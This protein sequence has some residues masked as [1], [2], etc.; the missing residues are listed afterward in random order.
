M[1]IAIKFRGI[2][3]ILLD[4][5]NKDDLLEK[6]KNALRLDD[7][8]L[9]DLE[10]PKNMDFS[11]EDEL[12][13]IN[14][15][16]TLQFIPDL[17]KNVILR[18]I[19]LDD[20]EP[21]I[22]LPTAADQ[23]PDEKNSAALPEKVVELADLLKD[24][25]TKAILAKEPG[26]WVNSD[27][28]TLRQYLRNT[29]TLILSG[30]DDGENLYPELL[31]LCSPT[32][33]RLHL[34]N[35][36]IGEPSE[37]PAGS[38]ANSLQKFTA[39]EELELDP[40]SMGDNFHHQRHLRL[41]LQ[42]IPEGIKKLGL[43]RITIE[44]EDSMQML[45]DVLPTFTKLE[46]LK[47][48]N[49][50][51]INRSDEVTR[52]FMMVLSSLPNL[53][54]LDLSVNTLGGEKLRQLCE[55]LPRFPELEEIVLRHTEL[56]SASIDIL[57][58]VLP[59]C[60]K[61]RIIDLSWNEI[62]ERGVIKLSE[63]LPKCITLEEI[64]FERVIPYM[65][66]QARWIAIFGEALSRCLFLSVIKLSYNEL[67]NDGVEI[68]SEYLPQ[69]SK[70][71]KIELIGVGLTSVLAARALVAGLLDCPALLSV[72]ISNDAPEKSFVNEL[73][74][75]IS[76]ATLSSFIFFSHLES[77]FSGNE[78]GYE[79]IADAME[80]NTSITYLE[81][82][83]PFVL[84]RRTDI[85]IKVRT[86][87]QQT[88]RYVERN[89]ALIPA[90]IS[91]Q[92]SVLDE[93]LPSVVRQLTSQ[94]LNDDVNSSAVLGSLGRIEFFLNKVRP[95]WGDFVQDKKGE[96]RYWADF[97]TEEEAEDA[98]NTLRLLLPNY[99]LGENMIR[100]GSTL[101]ITI[102]P[103]ALRELALAK[104]KTLYP[105]QKF[106]SETLFFAGEDKTPA[107][108]LEIKS[109]EDVLNTTNTTSETPPTA[110][111]NVPV[112]SCIV[113]MLKENAN[114]PTLSSILTSDA[115]SALEGVM[116][117]QALTT[118]FSRY[119]QKPEH[120]QALINI[121][122]DKLDED[123]IPFVAPGSVEFNTY[124]R[125]VECLQQ[126]Q[127]KLETVPD[128]KPQNTGQLTVIGPTLFSGS[129]AS[130]T[131][132]PSTPSAQASISSTSTFPGLIPLEIEEDK[133]NRGGEYR[134]K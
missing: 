87:I 14:L 104:P 103:Q 108:R 91:A 75:L 78:E 8:T 56:V 101:S 132:S 100:D 2:T 13:E 15:N 123:A 23:A 80:F 46:R 122:L 79:A 86:A 31:F 30:P 7:L 57:A 96:N 29:T 106:K 62:F 35:F 9:K 121:F 26:T 5:N 127:R 98:E 19:S 55:Y 116:S 58:P 6:A 16:L 20:E 12:Y 44:E 65:T 134:K 102:L 74:P 10:L 115:R 70:L 76:E 83:R 85:P 37:N 88:K 133:D 40:Q 126:I 1:R 42:S 28:A 50:G 3:Y 52:N 120:Y 36:S 111:D 4:V 21:E 129:S 59:G 112:S 54:A 84:S 43:S 93:Y 64:Y 51:Y 77:N 109:Q 61:L 90:Q 94:Y 113:S 131:A 48:I 125:C 17:G 110:M 22:Q 130:S 32:L 114:L 11:S 63:Y 41:I 49:I 107:N 99:V 97:G 95:S 81:L 27:K 117:D 72:S 24:P 18:A 39:L 34:R 124:T 45:C 33:R 118:W 25:T 68:L 69:C 53:R 128:V 38:L 67:S 105:K 119:W 73:T 71:E 89:R 47:L 66:G 60:P 92:L 82:C